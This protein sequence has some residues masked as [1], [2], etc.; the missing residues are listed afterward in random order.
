MTHDIT[1]TLYWRQN[2]KYVM[3]NVRGH[4]KEGYSLLEAMRPTIE[5]INYCLSKG[6]I[7]PDSNTT[8]GFI[9]RDIY[10]SV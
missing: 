8:I 5:H 9:E 3:R 10:K 6:Y 1:M 2:K 7:L 4:L